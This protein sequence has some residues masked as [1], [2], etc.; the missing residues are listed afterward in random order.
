[1]AFS[2][3]QVTTLTASFAEDLDAYR[4][5]GADGIGIWE[6]KLPDGGDAEA[7]EAFEASGLG[8]AA[9]VPLIPS[10][11]SLPLMEG[12]S[13]PPERVEAI[14]AS[15]HRLSPFRPSGIVCLTGP[16]QERDP[17]EARAIVVDGLRTVAAEA[18]RAGVRVGLEPINR[19]GGENWTI[20]S[21]IPEAVELLDAAAHPALGLQVDTWHL[22]NT[23]TLLEDIRR[24]AGR[25]V[26]VHVADWREPTR[27]WADRV[28]PG[29]G[30]ADLPTI[31]GALDAAG[32]DGFYDVEIFSDN[33]TF[34]NAWPDSLWDVPAEQL[35]RRCRESFDRAWDA[36]IR[37]GVDRVSPGAL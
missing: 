10:I 5:A 33:G 2:I 12:P 15:I 27:D 17:D 35:A 31:L 30:V 8:S 29:D 21:S 28:L 14:C 9:A 23:D 1:M 32:W 3:S 34:G 20:I 18:E 36:R 19:V 13:D 6:L 25:F 22:W 24:E 37:L 7:L 26:G 4:K 11:L 16:A